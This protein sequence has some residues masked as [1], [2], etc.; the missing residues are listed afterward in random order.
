MNVLSLS[1]TIA[2]AVSLFS[3]SLMASVP[4]GPVQAAP[5]QASAAQ[6]ADVEYER[7]IAPILKTYCAGCHNDT[8]KEG[9][10]S[11]ISLGAL[12]A[13]TEDGPV[14]VASKPEESKLF[15]VI[16]GAAE[17]QMPPKEEPQLKPEQIARLREW[18]AQGARGELKPSELMSKLSVPKL[19]KDRNAAKQV[20]AVCGAGSGRLAVGKFGSVELQTSEGK[21]VWLF[22]QLAGKVNQIRLSP[23]GKSLVVASGIAGVAGEVVLL[24]VESGEVQL[25]LQGHADAAYCASA[26]ADGKWIASGSYDKTVILWDRASGKVA[27]TLTGHNGAIYDLDF[28]ATSSVL[29]TGSAD[30]TVKVWSASGNRLDTLGQP[31]GEVLSVRFSPDGNHLFAA[32]VDRQIRKWKLESRKEPMNNPMLVARFAHE[33]DVLQIEFMG[34]DRLVS[35]S[36]DRTVK[37]WDTDQ[38]RPLGQ[39][40]LVKEQPVGIVAGLGESI[41]VLTMNGDATEIASDV[42]EK[43]AKSAEQKRASGEVASREASRTPIMANDEAKPVS[44]MET[45]P[46]DKLENAPKVDLPAQIAGVIEARGA[47]DADQDLY[48]FSAKAGERWILGVNAARAESPLDSR[49]EILDEYGKSLVQTRLQ[50]MRESYFTFRGKDGST[51]DDFRVHNWEDMELNEYLYAGGEIVKLWLYPRGPDSGFKVY[52][53]TGARY[54]YF[55]TTPTSHA[56][57]ATAYIVRELVDE[58]EALPNGLPVFPIYYENDDDSLR[59]WGK[60]SR[61][62]FV[63]PRTGD[64]FVKIRDARGFGG[65]DFKYSLEILQPRPDFTI[66]VSGTK[67]K[68]PVGSGREW[69]VTA[70]RMDELEEEILV[71]VRGLP[72]GFVATNPL[73]IEAGQMAALGTIY[74]TNDAQKLLA[75]SA[76][77]APATQKFELSLLAKSLHAGQWIEHELKEKI[78]LELMS[79]PELR[80]RLVDVNDA[81]LELEELTIRPGQTISARVVIDRNDVKGPVSFGGDDSGRNLPH[82]TIVDNIGLNGLLLPD[83]VNDR[84]FFITAAKW[85]APQRRQI[86][87]RSQSKDNPTSKPIWLKIVPSQ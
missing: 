82:G 25:R 56:L 21:V 71:E 7:D 46:N 14:V 78:E 53:G 37:L 36:V 41:Q 63:A 67:L 79:A 45:E 85:M 55:G 76:D 34:S 44:V 10:L 51:S 23:D 54:T 75:A 13:G 83:G 57:G 8:D 26:S 17:P 15:Q 16:S 42:L 20:T 80:V 4:A 77:G 43:L 64:Y 74:A 62:S 58:E 6:A 33:D 70:T 11:L 39:I 35:T 81:N 12:R 27:R 49:I 40:A 29:A 86:H 24:N 32:G 48:R 87:L 22:D 38:I 31:Q 3:I 69:Q 52:P 9:E 61:L 68:M 72:E 1:G 66:Q 50:A 18:I 65:A 30:Q 47:N 59:R 19:A 5:V 28:D 73:V 2:W 84:E 60:D